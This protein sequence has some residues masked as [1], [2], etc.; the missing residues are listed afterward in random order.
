MTPGIFAAASMV[1]IDRFVDD[2]PSAKHQGG[3]M[4]GL[5][6][7][8]KSVRGK[9]RTF[10]AVMAG[11]AFLVV[12]A[13]A[14]ALPATEPDYDV[15]VEPMPAPDLTVSATAETEWSVNYQGRYIREVTIWFT[16]K[17]VGNR[18][19]GPFTVVQKV[20]HLIWFGSGGWTGERT[21]YVGG[22]A[23]GASQRL[24]AVWVNDEACVKALAIADSG[25]KIVER[26]E[27]NNHRYMISERSP[28][29]CG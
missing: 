11:M 10:M 8:K 20:N 28:G 16:V 2:R 25:K 22:L 23:A 27:A 13:A 5:R 24:A 26:N 9:V 7:S 4:N 18:A 21:V 15:E 6:N 3:T 1:V 17:N 12:P 14:Q 19:A 29:A